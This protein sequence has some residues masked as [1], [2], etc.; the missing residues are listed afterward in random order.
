MSII[1]KY[2]YFII[3]MLILG[4]VFIINKQ[5]GIKSVQISFNSFKQMLLYIPPIFI[6]LGLLDVW[7]PRDT[8]V[9]LMGEK[10]GIRGI[11]LAFAVGAVA[12]GPLYGAF[13]VAAVF[14]KKGVK[15]TNLLIFIG[16]WSCAKIGMVLFEIAALGAKFAFTRLLIDIPVIIIMAFFIAHL[17][18]EDEIKKIYKKAEEL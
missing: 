16:T 2:K 17:V 13:P 5:T 6:L 3:T 4:I 1:K 8:M 12:A 10:S 18:G 14:M 9:Q 15:F 11:F 7:I